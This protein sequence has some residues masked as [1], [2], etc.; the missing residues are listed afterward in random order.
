ME[1]NTNEENNNKERYSD[2]S[3][4]GV[5]GALVFTILAFVAMYLLSKFI[6]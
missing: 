2:S 1:N 5:V 3:G 6:G 4:T